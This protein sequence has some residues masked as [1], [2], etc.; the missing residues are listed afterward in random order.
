MSLNLPADS[1]T[2]TPLRTVPIHT[3]DRGLYKTCRRRWLWGSHLNRG[4]EPVQKAKPLWFGE[5]I[6][7]AMK[8]FHGPSK[9]S[10][11]IVAFLE[12]ARLCKEEYPDRLPDDMPELLELGKGMLDH[13]MT[14][15]ETRDGLQTYVFNGVPQVEVTFEIE[16]PIDPELLAAAGIDRVVYR[17]TKDRVVYDPEYDALWVLDYKTAAVIETNHLNV[18]P[19]IS[20]YLWAATAIYDKPIMGFIYQQHKKTTPKEPR[21]LKS[22]HVSVDKNQQTTFK[23]Y[24]QAIKKT[25]G[26]YKNSGNP[27][28]LEVLNM[29][30]TR[31]N[32]TSDG[33]IR[34]DKV[35]RNE[36]YIQ[37]TGHKIL[38]EVSEMVNPNTSMYPHEGRHCIMCPFMS[39]CISIDDGSDYESELNDE[40]LYRVR[41][42]ASSEWE[43]ISTDNLGGILHSRKAVIQHDR[44]GKPYADAGTLQSTNSDSINAS[45][46]EPSG[47]IYL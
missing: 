44:S 27:K 46:E 37:A 39:A 14:W 31:E 21:I 23:K 36:H 34:R 15:L 4:L 2:S 11:I 25:Y 45:N 28:H 26:H 41:S 3:S 32:E 12:Y 24:A 40:R 1:P 22:G 17:G 13:Y 30:A 9:Y 20:S 7:F 47:N 6:H 29:L 8:E 43:I 33:F 10:D 42:R 16:L 18:D 5:A 35:Y 38:L 19:Q